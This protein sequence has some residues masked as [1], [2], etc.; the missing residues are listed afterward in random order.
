MPRL[1]Y[2]EENEKTSHAR[3]LIESAKRTGAPDPRVVSLMTRGKLGIA[4]VEYWNKLLYQ[5]VLPPKLKEMCGIKI[6][7]AHQCGYCS[8]VRSNVAK[9]EGLTEAIIGDL[10][11]FSG[12]RHFSTREKAAL[13]YADLFKQGEHAIDKDEVYAD[14][15]KHFSDEEIIELGLFCA[16]VDGAGKFV[17]SLNVVSW[18]E[19]CALDPKLKNGAAP[20][21]AE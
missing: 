4:W 8:T 7:V 6:S 16:E 3:E 5:G 15:A 11:D 2:I 9:A 13:H 18:E 20:L 17:K 10:F 14:L 12:S 21:A 1:R 19:A